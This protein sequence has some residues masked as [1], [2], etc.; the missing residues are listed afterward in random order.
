MYAESLQ[1]VEGGWG[2]GLGGIIIGF[3]LLRGS[4]VVGVVGF[5]VQTKSVAWV[6]VIWEMGDGPG[7]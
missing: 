3:L 7:W 4:R 5:I 6:C 2:C 1:C